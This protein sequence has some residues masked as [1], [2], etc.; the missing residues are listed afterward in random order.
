[1]PAGP[2]PQNNTYVASVTPVGTDTTAD[3][4]E[5]CIQGCLDDTNCVYWSWWAPSVCPDEPTFVDCLHVLQCW[6]ERIPCARERRLPTRQPGAC[7]L[8]AQ[9]CAG[10]RACRP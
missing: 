2:P 8:L 5:A 9:P 3:T 1:M 7:A 6:R 4:A 10:G